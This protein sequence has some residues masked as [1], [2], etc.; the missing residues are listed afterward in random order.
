MHCCPCSAFQRFRVTLRRLYSS[1]LEVLLTGLWGMGGHS[2][3]RERLSGYDLAP[4]DT[5]PVLTGVCTSGLSA[6]DT[7]ETDTKLYDA[8]S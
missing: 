5:E 2:W 7:V 3:V 6:I 8:R 4:S 1:V